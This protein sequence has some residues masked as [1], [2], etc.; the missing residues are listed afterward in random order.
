MANSSIIKSELTKIL[1]QVSFGEDE[2]VQRYTGTHYSKGTHS[3]DEAISGLVTLNENELI[4]VYK[5]GKRLARR[6]PEMAFYYFK[7][8]PDAITHFSFNDMEKWVEYGI[9]LYEGYGVV[10]AR[11]FFKGITRD[12]INKIRTVGLQ[13]GD[14]KNILNLYINALSGRDLKITTGNETY[15]DT[16]TIYLP[17]VIKEFT[18]KEDNFKVY[19]L[20]TVY[21][22]AQIRYR[23]FDLVLDRITET[24]EYLNEKYKKNSS[25]GLSAFEKFFSFFPDRD[26]ALKIYEIVDNARIEHYIFIEFKGLYRDLAFIKKAILNN[27]VTPAELTE[28]EIAVY[29]IQKALMTN[30]EFGIHSDTPSIVTKKCISLINE[31]LTVQPSSEDSARATA[32]IYSIITGLD[33]VYNGIRDILYI[34]NIKP[35]EITLGINLTK[36]EL[37]NSLSDIYKLIGESP[38]NRSLEDL[39]EDIKEDFSFLEFFNLEDVLLKLGITLPDEILDEI[40]DKLEKQL[41][42]MGELDS[43]MFVKVLESTN[44][45]VRAQIRSLSTTYQVEMEDKDLVDAILYD[46]W[47]YEVGNYRAAWCSLKEKEVAKKSDKFVDKTLDKYSSLLLMV[48]RQFERL[49][50]EYKKLNRH[51]EGEDIDLDAVIEAMIDMY[52][53]LQPSDDLYIKI[54]KNDRDIAV[55]FLVDMS[56]STTG[57]VMDTEKDSLVIMCEALDYLN[58]KY[59]IYGFSGKTRKQCDFYKIKTFDENYDINVKQRISGMKAFDY[60]RMG[61]PIRH[62]TKIMD[63]QAAKTKIMIILSDG[64]PE[65]FDEYKGDHGIEDTK[66]A[67][68]EAKRKHITPFCITIDTEARDYIQHMYGDVNYII[69]DDIN[70]LPQ[71]LPEIYRKL[72][73]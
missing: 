12:I 61:A 5:L 53:G 34:G 19:K 9:E 17:S 50:P 68:T 62:L 52:A 51:K 6:D 25:T 28:K 46:E 42:E 24:I 66:K 21:K 29:D 38:S 8:A 70:K 59:A 56:G 47:D 73:I 35:E 44:K 55:A 65:D 60:T 40:I 31:M 54:D 37:I 41:G 2:I 36:Q 13:F 57:W 45:L 49:R 72:T 64:K 33:G 58:D 43:N 14:I 32:Q 20:L 16:R 22:Y 63:Q 1:G 67:L 48:R 71:K 27:M 15:T 39:V 30:Q 4:G 26:L 11:N 3:I 69:L 23:S 18:S 10:P 7:T